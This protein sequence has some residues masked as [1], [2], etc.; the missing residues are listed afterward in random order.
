MDP[1]SR[2]AGRLSLGTKPEPPGLASPRLPPRLTAGAPRS[3]AT[4]APG[5]PQSEAHA[6]RSPPTHTL[7]D[8]A[9]GP[10]GAKD[11]LAA[12]APPGR[13]P[14]GT[15][16]WRRRCRPRPPP[17]SGAP[18]DASGLAGQGRSEAP[19]ENGVPVWGRGCPLGPAADQPTT[20]ARP[21]PPHPEWALP[22][23]CLPLNLRSVGGS[24]TRI[25]SCFAM[26][27]EADAI[28]ETA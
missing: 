6:L 16:R 19:P 11:E 12:R 17:H 25:C 23:H 1:G 10:S 2:A 4:P 5:P 24:R 27:P 22:S 15:A 3:S 7:A 20:T 21:T 18:R 8:N 28:G 14:R 9:R 26:A 13:R